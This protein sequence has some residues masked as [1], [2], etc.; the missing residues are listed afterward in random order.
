MK[1]PFKAAPGVATVNGA[2]V[3]SSG[4]VMLTEAEARYDLAHGRISPEAAD[5]SPSAAEVLA[6]EQDPPAPR[7]R[8]RGQPK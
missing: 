2:A 6:A 1:K 5:P 8:R 3:P 7:R 4:V